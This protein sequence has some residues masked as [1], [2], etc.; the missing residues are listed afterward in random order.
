MARARDYTSLEDAARVQELASLRWSATAEAPASIH[1]GDIPWR[2]LSAADEPDRFAL[3]L[4]EDDDGVAAWGWLTRPDELELA[5]APG[6]E[7][8]LLDD[9]LGWGE[10]AAESTL[11]VDSLDADQ[12][13]RGRLEARG[14]RPV[15]DDTLYIHTR[16]LDEIAAPSL[17]DGFTLRHVRL[18]D[19]LARRVD[20]HRSAF[21]R[22]ERPSRLTVET[23]DAVTRIW[24][25]RPELDM[26]V[27]APDGSFASFCLSW[28]DEDAR[29]GLLEPVGTHEHHRRAGL[30][31]AACLGALRALADAGARRAV[32]S[33]ATDEARALYRNIGF[34]EAGRYEWL[35]RG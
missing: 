3:R 23:Y 7:D 27:E 32:V 17:P 33:A 34:V 8:E 29:V 11:K 18:P 25:Y 30:A 28:L 19:D 24:P 26:V 10:S 22:P 16:A 9:I 12:G 1:V 15:P 6:R 20:V 31:S 21:G 13:L 35:S 4:W 5:I 14:Y 2:L